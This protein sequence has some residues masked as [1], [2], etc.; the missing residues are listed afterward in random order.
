MMNHPTSA[1]LFAA[2]QLG[3]DVSPSAAIREHLDLCAVCRVQA[4]RMLEPARATSTALPDLTRLLASSPS[5]DSRLVSALNAGRRVA[6]PKPSQL[7]RAGRNEAL[8]VW[9]RRDLDDEVFVF[10]VVLDIHLADDTS[11]ILPADQS[12]LGV[13]LAVMTAIPAVIP[14]QALIG[15]VGLLPIGDHVEELLASDHASKHL[16]VGPAIESEDDQRLDYRLALGGLLHALSLDPSDVSDDEPTWLEETRP[17][18]VR[19]D[20]LDA[21][22]GEAEAVSE[23]HPGVRIARLP[24]STATVDEAHRLI[25]CGRALNLDASLLLLHLEGP[26]ARTML[27]ADLI[28]VACRQFAHVYP[29]VAGF[30]LVT[31]PDL[32]CVI[33]PVE[34]TVQAVTAPSGQR[35]PPGISMSALA[36]VDALFKYF[37]GVDQMW[38]PFDRYVRETS[39]TNVT[40]ITDLRVDSAMAEIL[41]AGTRARTP[42]KKAAWTGLRA[43]AAV[44]L[45][46]LILSVTAGRDPNTAVNVYLSSEEE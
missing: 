6:D 11:L 39:A 44:D 19:G 42:A 18:D 5:L 14:K 16:M 7:W 10:P 43:R 2:L 1:E 13:P 8:L 4:S 46:E 3:V 9:I 41:S 15:P 17:P 27:E 31:S 40:A 36:L 38:E 34:D 20:I 33:V 29:D 22:V 30:A 37:D 21:L 23:R 35:R 26:R 45:R 12:P 28:A 25:V 32:S 24:F